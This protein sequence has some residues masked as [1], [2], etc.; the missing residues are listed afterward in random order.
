MKGAFIVIEGLEGAGKS[1]VITAVA[2]FLQDKGHAVQ[3]TREPGGTP[4]AE[5]I[6]E[7]VKHDWQSEE[8]TQ[9]TE[10]LLMYAARSQLVHNV[11]KPALVAGK[12][13][14]GDRHNLSSIAYQGGGRQVPTETLNQ[15]KE[16][17]LGD[18]SPQLS[19]YLDIEPLEGLKRARGRGELD[20]IER[21][22][23]AFF[24]RARARYLQ[25]IQILKAQNTYSAYVIDASASIEKVQ[26]AVLSSLHE[27]YERSFA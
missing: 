27:W 14:I 26:H 20:R 25:E 24:D 1:T 13:V 22:G 21:A 7:C 2:S 16:M 9:E 6:R 10:L 17:T 18:F 8:V 15:L 11:I 5:A 19:L 23:S 4:M 3:C 12:F